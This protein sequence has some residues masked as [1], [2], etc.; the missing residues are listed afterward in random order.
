MSKRLRRL[1]R[2]NGE[3]M[4]FTNFICS[5]LSALFAAFTNSPFFGF[6]AG[7]LNSILTGFGCGVSG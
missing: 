5:I 6:I 3:I 4:D 7:I 2:G 1:P